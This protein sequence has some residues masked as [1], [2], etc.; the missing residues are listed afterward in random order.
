MD[1]AVRPIHMILK[2][3]LMIWVTVVMLITVNLP[4]T[5]SVSSWIMKINKASAEVNFAG[6]F[7]YV[8]DGRIEAM[9][10]V[11]RVT[12]G[13][14]QERLYSLHGEAREVIRDKNRVWCFMPDQQMGVYD[15]RQMSESGFPRILPGNVA[16]LSK[17]Y[18]FK[19]GKEARIANR[20]AHQLY[21]LPNDHY[22]Y[23]YTLWADKES[24]LVLRSDMTDEKEEIIEQYM[25]VNVDIG[26]P[27][28]DVQLQATSN[29]DEF[30]WFGDF[31]SPMS[32]PLESSDWRVNQMPDG[33][34]LSKHIRRVSPTEAGEV[35]HLVYTDGLATLS[36]FINEAKE[37]QSGLGGLSRMGAVHVYRDTVN[38][39]NI[40]VIG[41][42]PARTVELVASGIVYQP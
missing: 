24:G 12:D 30:E 37:G 1:S 4:A 2:R 32:T 13:M 22:R 6:T 35:E 15:H 20:L 7:I 3:L 23:G 9:E 28:S 19:E 14:M 11:R 21:I 33:Y 38:Y 31:K 17:N 10:V 8:H 27:I 25:F 34:R 41:E 42:V 40:T 16:E 29:K 18:H 5:A 39:H 36:V 26:G